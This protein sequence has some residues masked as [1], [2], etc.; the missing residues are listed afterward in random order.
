MP[1]RVG[2]DEDVAARAHL[3]DLAVDRERPRS[4]DA[5]V[6]L[7][8]ARFEL[9]VLGPDLPGREVDLVETE[10]RAAERVS[11]H[12]ERAP[13]GLDVVGVER[14]VGHGSLLAGVVSARKT[15]LPDR[16]L[17]VYIRKTPNV[18]SGTGALA[19]AASPS[20]STRRVSTRVDDPVVPE[21]RGREVRRALAL[22]GRRG[23]RPG[24][25]PPPSRA[26]SPPARRPSPRC[27]RSATSRAGAGRRRGRTSRSC[28]RRTSRR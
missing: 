26:R 13:G 15:R 12:P 18:V 4:G 22:V 16:A 6:D 1:L 17:A 11:H 7:L 9:V 24:R 14:L 23:S 21:A 20:A 28:R 2:R 27:G 25:R 3:H 5:V 10:G 19:A 8:L